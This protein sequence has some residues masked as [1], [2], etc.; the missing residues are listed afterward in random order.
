M[1]I[2]RSPFHSW[3]P[4]VI[5]NLTWNNCLILSTWQKIIPIIILSYC[6]SN[7]IIIMSAILSSFTGRLMGI[8]QTNLKLLIAFSSINHISWIIL[9]LIINFSIWIIYFGVY[10]FINF[11]LIINFKHL[12]LNFLRQIYTNNLSSPIKIF[13][14]INF[15]SLGGLPPFVGFLPKWILINF[16]VLNQ[17]YLIRIILI[18]RSLINLFFYLRINFTSL[19]LNNSQLRWIKQKKL[20]LTSIIYILSYFSFNCLIYI[21]YLREVN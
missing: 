6:L 8:N 14:L 12:N 7:H 2:G 19:I 1:K 13:L 5:K 9:A 3:F 18:M 21:T 4:Q 20:N 17:I 15:L 10:S 16:L 11:I